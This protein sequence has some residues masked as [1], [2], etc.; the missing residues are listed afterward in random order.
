MASSS[1]PSAVIVAGRQGIPRTAPPPGSCTSAPSPSDRPD[2]G[3]PCGS[4]IWRSSVFFGGQIAVEALRAL[5]EDGCATTRAWRSF[6]LVAVRVIEP[7]L[8]RARNRLLFGQLL[9]LIDH[10]REETQ[11]PGQ[12]HIPLRYGLKLGVVVLRCSAI[13]D[14]KPPS[15]ESQILDRMLANGPTDTAIPIV[16]GMNHFEPGMRMTFGANRPR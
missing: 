16:E 3:S 15:A 7:G 5:S 4:G 6:N 10:A 2:R 9:A 8:Y 14:D 11:P 12:I 1:T 13:A